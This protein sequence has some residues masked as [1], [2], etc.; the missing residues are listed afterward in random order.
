MSLCTDEGL[1]LRIFLAC[2]L[3]CFVHSSEA[4]RADLEANS[5]N[6]AFNTEYIIHTWVC[7]YQSET[8]AWPTDSVISSA[9]L[10]LVGRTPNFEEFD[11]NITGVQSE[12]FG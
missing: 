8:A 11:E 1:K 4:S 2:A 3:K 5:F 10:Q 7:K 6:L 9:R 12:V